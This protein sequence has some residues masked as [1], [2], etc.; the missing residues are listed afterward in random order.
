[1]QVSQQAVIGVSSYEQEHA[2]SFELALDQ[3]SMETLKLPSLAA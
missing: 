1:M 3:M 2:S